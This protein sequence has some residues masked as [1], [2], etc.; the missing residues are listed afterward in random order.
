MH[1]EI[2]NH[3][4]INMS[5]QRMNELAP[6]SNGAPATS[7]AVRLKTISKSPVP[8]GKTLLAVSD[9]QNEEAA[10]T[11]RSFKFGAPPN[12]LGHQMVTKILPDGS[13]NWFAT[14]TTNALLGFL[15]VADQ[16]RINVTNATRVHAPEAPLRNTPFFEEANRP[17]LPGENLFADVDPVK[18]WRRFNNILS[19]FVANSG[20]EARPAPTWDQEP[21]YQESTSKREVQDGKMFC[22]NSRPRGGERARRRRHRGGPR[23]RGGATEGRGGRGSTAATNDAVGFE[24]THLFYPR[25]R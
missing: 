18:E 25:G 22:P 16:L 4:P 17:L 2:A 7:C 10:Q 15:P 12:T 1:E 19:G 21:A 24:D 13:K 9:Y 5:D 14:A 6:D 11:A 8:G 3:L 23:S 20:T